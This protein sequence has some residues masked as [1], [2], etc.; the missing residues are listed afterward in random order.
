MR[1]KIAAL[2]LVFCTGCA[3]LYAKGA[4]H[5]ERGLSAA[6]EAWGE[7]FVE[8]L[9]HC[10]EIAPPKTDE[11][12]LCFGDIDKIDKEVATAM[13]IAVAALR[14]FWI[15]YAAGADP[16]DLAKHLAEIERAVR[17]LPD[18]FFGRLK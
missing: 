9:E 10:K 16:K 2:M 7:F 17:D 12:E 18:E 5:T 11:A 14:S 13:E 6:N 3:S 4:V 15:A 1:Q 8:E